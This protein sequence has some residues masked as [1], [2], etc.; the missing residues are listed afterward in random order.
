[1]SDNSAQNRLFRKT[2]LER[3]STPDQLD[4]LVT[5]SGAWAWLATLFICIL[6]AGATA[7]S[8]TGAI[9]SY[10]KAEGLIVKRGGQAFDVVAPEG[11]RIV[12]LTV[13]IGD[14]IK[15]GDVIGQIDQPQLRLDLIHASEVVAERELRLKRLTEIF[16]GERMMSDQ[17]LTAQKGGLAEFRTAATERRDELKENFS[18]LDEL[19]AKGLITRNAVAS[20]RAQFHQA[21]QEIR[22]ATSDIIALDREASQLAARHERDLLTAED[23][24]QNAHREASRIA[25][26]LKR[27][28][29]L[30]AEL[31]GQVSEIKATVGMRV[32]RG[33]AIVSLARGDG[34]LEAM[35]FIPPDKG[36]DI[37]IG[38]TVAVQPAHI[39]KE[40]FGAILG[41]VRVVSGF[42]VSLERM[43][44]ILQNENLVKRFSASGAHYLARVELIE[45]GATASGLRWSSGDGPSV[46]ISPGSVATA[47]IT[48]RERAPIDLVV[49]A[50]RRYTG[51]GY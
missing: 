11:G 40:E 25:D 15:S 21:E 42:P 46:Q 50:M 49:P 2:A 4:Q 37:Q 51:F 29:T 44:A 3:L 23:D 24:L 45:D 20:A 30:R 34:G 47:E 5:V 9:P 38:Q 14:Q 39:K 12:T 28:E 18:G 13:A 41:T 43:R 8:F 31:P 35:I 6:L 48:V 36:K 7:W 26:V 27:A 10:V 32:E 19:G 17:L 16:D 22:S 33:V 1:M